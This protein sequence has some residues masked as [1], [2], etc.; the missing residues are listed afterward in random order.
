MC[1]LEE[2]HQVFDLSHWYISRHLYYGTSPNLGK[3]V[4][5]WSAS[6]TANPRYAEQ[7]AGERTAEA[8]GV[9]AGAKGVPCAPEVSGW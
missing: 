1:I 4:I 7:D 5:Y 3:M 6:Q 2:A 9:L 8:A